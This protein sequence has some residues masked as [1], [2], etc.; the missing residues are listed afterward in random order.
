MA[1]PKMKT[2]IRWK[3]PK[4]LWSLGM[5]GAWQSTLLERLCLEATSMVCS[6]SQADIMALY[7]ICRKGRIKQVSLHITFVSPY[8]PFVYLYYI[9]IRTSYNLDPDKYIYHVISCI[10]LTVLLTVSC[11][12][13]APAAI[14]VHGRAFTQCLGCGCCRV[15]W[16]SLLESDPGSTRLTGR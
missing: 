4:L 13:P 10:S 15:G 6:G 7:I 16:A 3:V 8:Y 12:G 2:A 5:L 14:L 11:A 9:S 1:P